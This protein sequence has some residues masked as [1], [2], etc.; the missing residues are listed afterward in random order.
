MR[1]KLPYSLAAAAFFFAC[2]ALLCGES[3]ASGETRPL[4]EVSIPF[5][6]GGVVRALLPDGREFVLGRVVKLPE[7]TRWPSYTA[8]AWG[9]P[10]TVT[11]SAVNAVHILI[12]VESGKGRTMSVIPAETI[13][14]AAGPGAA[15][16]LDCKGGTSFFG[17]WAPPAGTPL[18]V[19][20]EGL[21]LRS[22]E[23]GLPERGDELIL[24]VSEGDIPYMVE[25]ENRPGGRVIAWSASRAEIAARVVRPLGGT[26]RFEGTLYQGPGRIRANHSGVIDISTSRYG[27]IGGF[28]IIPW[29]HALSSPE[30]QGSWQMTQWM[31]IAHPD[32]RSMMGGTEPL[33]AGG[34]V[35]GTQ[36][37][38]SLWDIWSTYGR[39][40]LV[41]ARIDGGPWESLPVA[42]GRDD[43]VLKSVT[44][45]RI[46]FP[47]SKEPRH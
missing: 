31:I 11:A 26:G 9:S 34:L 8:S 43:G 41:I 15:V 29:D 35:P 45:L 36:A 3:R 5:E 37:G 21:P 42:S 22:I 27:S 38:E 40:P 4:Y 14:P 47:R 20:R 13:A 25:F 6:E 18:F 12:G 17:A 39:K 32:G 28:Q 30:M 1:M 2:A 46:Y 19:R 33:F 44:H 10:G 7:R 24:K 16:V 23:D